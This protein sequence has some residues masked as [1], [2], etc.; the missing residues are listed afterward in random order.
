MKLHPL[1]LLGALF[2]TLVFAAVN[3]SAVKITAYGAWLS[4]NADCS[5]PLEILNATAGTEIDIQQSPTIAQKAIPAGTYKCLILKID[6]VLKI[7]PATSDLP[8][9]VAGTEFKLEICK[10]GNT[11]KTSKDP[12]TGATVTCTDSTTTPDK[13]FVYVSRNSLCTG[14]ASAG[15]GCDAF[16]QSFL[17]PTKVNDGTNGIKLG[18]DI[19]IAADTTGSFVINSDGKVA[20]NGG[21]CGMDPPAFSYK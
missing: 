7:T 15:G 16:I 18:A 3:A 2:P 12:I 6:D 14:E 21:S 17:P 9:C 10:T 5:S 4:T 20:N 19:T 13:V 11:V 8:G 1:A